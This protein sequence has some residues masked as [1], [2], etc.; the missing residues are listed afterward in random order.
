M[1]NFRSNREY[2]AVAFQEVERS[3]SNE[4]RLPI[5]IGGA[6]RFIKQLF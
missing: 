3:D 4:R 2:A 6:D 5:E 1:F